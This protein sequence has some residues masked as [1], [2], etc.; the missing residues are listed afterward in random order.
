LEEVMVIFNFEYH[1]DEVDQNQIVSIFTVQS[2]DSFVNRNVTNGG[3][4]EELD[5]GSSIREEEDET[6]L[7]EDRFVARHK[8]YVIIISWE[9][10]IHTFVFS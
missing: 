5:H 8:E 7:D 10:N 9:Q 2:L 3:C 4:E 1:G 6:N